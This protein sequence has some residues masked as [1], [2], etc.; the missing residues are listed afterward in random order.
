MKCF[1]YLGKK[2]DEAE[3]QWIIK[4]K[5][6]LVVEFVNPRL[7]T[8]AW[9]G[10][11]RALNWSKNKNRAVKQSSGPSGVSLSLS[12]SPLLLTSTTTP[13]RWSHYWVTENIR[14]FFGGVLSEN[15]INQG[16]HLSVLLH[17][18]LSCSTTYMLYN[19]YIQLIH[20]KS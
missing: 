9:A 12:L 7:L 6:F 18:T 17:S 15:L 1:F 11:G 14:P 10:L 2:R 4:N 16:N 8:A 19:I 20:L 13:V 3:Q 5:S